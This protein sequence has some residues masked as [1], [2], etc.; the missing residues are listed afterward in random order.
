[1]GPGGAPADPRLERRLALG[2]FLVVFVWT[3]VLA[4]LFFLQVV[5]GD[6]FRVS[7]ERNSVRTH[8]V[9]A[10][11]GIVRDRNGVILVDSRPAFGVFVIPHEAGDLP[12]TVRRVSLLT[13]EPQATLSKRLG[14]PRG[15]ERFQPHALVHDLDRESLARIE[16]RLW[17]LP[18]VITQA[19]PLRDYRFGV[20]AAHVLGTL[21]EINRRQ[22]SSR[23]YAGYRLGDVVGQSGVESLLEPQLRGRP[24]G[25]SVLVDVQGRELEILRE[26]APQAGYNVVLTLDHRVQ[27]AAEEALDAT[28]RAGAIV[29][30]DPRTGEVL[31]LVSRPAFDP[32]RFAAGIDPESWQEMVTDPRRAL[33]NRALQGQYPP[34]STYKVV[35]AIAGLEE[36][37]IRPD[38]TV[39]CGGS[40]RLGRRRY[41]CWKAGGHGE[42][43]LHRAIVESCDVFFYR[44]GLELGVDRLAYYARALGLGKRTGL[45]LGPEEAGLVPTAAWKERRFHEPWIQ[46]ETLSLAI[47]QGFNLLTPI[48]LASL[49]ASIANGGIRHR[50]YLVARIER[51]D[52]EAL[53][54]NEPEVLGAVPI[55][56]DT[57]NRVRKALHGVVHE[58]H[59]TGPVVRWLPGRIEA[60][61]KTG[62]AQ[63]VALSEEIDEED[64]PEHHRDHAWFVAYAP[65]DSPRIAVVVLVEHGGKG[66]RGAGPLARD[67]LQAFFA[68]EEAR[69]VRR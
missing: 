58:P 66:S 49:Y 30:L 54:V 20:S 28:G 8:R 19:S 29:A 38:T 65:A 56:Q 10:T 45:Q 42:V 53:R 51:P 68:S 69:V 37:V 31:A 64:V 6:R 63:V 34:G 47:G 36:K 60:A 39:Y 33:P 62:T 41:R 48:Q 22:L 7:A 40:F 24:G 16:A 9:P 32:N 21:G 1:M 18:G 27:Q 14:E 17:A 26:V 50:P 4:R 57:L 52:G 67:V 2:A 59:G 43:Q 12:D 44:V 11:R 15:R 5:E 35:T 23:R 55:S 13:E 46:G 3:V 61:A 25:R